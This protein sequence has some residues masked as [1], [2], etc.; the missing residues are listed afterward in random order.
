MDADG[1]TVNWTT[2]NA[3][4][5]IIAYL[6]LKGGRYFVGNETQRTS[7]GTRAKTGVGFTPTGILAFSVNATANA[8][9]AAHDR[10]AIGGASAAGTEGATW[11]G[12]T[13]SLA[14][15]SA[16]QS[17]VTDKV[18]RLIDTDGPAAADAEADLDSFDADGFT[19]DWTTADA[20]AREFVFICFGTPA[21][22]TVSAVAATATAAAPIPVILANPLYQTFGSIQ[23]LINPGDYASGAS[24]YFEVILK[25]SAAARSAHARLYNVTDGGEV[26]SSELSTQSE[27]ATRLRSSALSL[28]AGDKLYRADF[29]G[30]ASGDTY[31][32]Y[33]A[34]VLVDT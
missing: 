25:T 20:V 34:D 21:S 4:S 10:I 13:D 9:V 32:C 5:R 29:G 15:T 24:I 18:L 27:T 31:T 22:T 17:T 26:A 3:S 16:D 8:S 2:A 19:L 6:A 23:R 33:A 7:T 28:A 14:T 11:A 30:V 1:F 12:D